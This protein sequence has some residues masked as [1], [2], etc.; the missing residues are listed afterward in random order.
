[1]SDFAGL[2]SSPIELIWPFERWGP[3]VH[4]NSAR[5][6]PAEVDDFVARIA[7]GQDPA[8]ISGAALTMP[9]KA[10]RWDRSSK[11]RRCQ[12]PCLNPLAAT[13]G[14]ACCH[15]R[16]KPIGLSVNGKA[17]VRTL[18]PVSSDRL[19]CSSSEGPEL[20]LEA[21][22]RGERLRREPS[23][24]PPPSHSAAALVSLRCAAES[25]RSPIRSPMEPRRRPDRARLGKLLRGHRAERG[26]CRVLLSIG[27][28]L[29]NIEL[30][31]RLGLNRSPCAGARASRA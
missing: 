26:S 6:R 25:G 4:V 14:R 19:R 9:P 20:I 29:P 1:M 2:S 16:S 23:R 27:R 13:V 24:R 17:S 8:K 21:A 11:Q 18:L 22:A 3:A 30:A 12:P 28:R 15:G 10:R 31:Q 7:L 5:P